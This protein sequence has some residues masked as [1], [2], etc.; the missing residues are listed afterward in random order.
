MTADGNKCKPM[1]DF[2]SSKGWMNENLM[3]EWVDEVWLARR[4]PAPPDES[5]LTLDSAKCHLTELAKDAVKSSAKMV[6]IPA[7]LTKIL[8]PLDISVNKSFKSKL[9]Y[10][11][12]RWMI[13][14]DSHT[15]TKGGK[16]RHASLLEI[17][18]WIIE[19]C[20]EITPECI[21]NGFKKSAGE[22]MS[23]EE[24]D[25]ESNGEEEMALPP[26]LLQGIE[27][28]TFYSDEGEEFEGFEDQADENY[29]SEDEPVA[30]RPSAKTNRVPA[31]ILMR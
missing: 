1:V 29:E 22:E 4:N 24:S 16:Q 2:E 12:E 20:A 17:C 27:D 30:T 19:C 7:G 15:Y 21:K 18:N 3:Q 31:S 11:W 13:D 26:A 6:V 10:R 14:T 8:Q 9:K 23:D 5:G 28:M 25:N